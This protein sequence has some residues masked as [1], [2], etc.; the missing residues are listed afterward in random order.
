M[1]TGAANASTPVNSHSDNASARD[2][3]RQSEIQAV[4]IEEEVVHVHHEDAVLV[5]M[6]LEALLSEIFASLCKNFR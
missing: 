5:A 3:V 2:A 4:L 1:L 6:R